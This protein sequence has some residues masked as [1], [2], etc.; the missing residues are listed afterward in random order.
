VVDAIRCGELSNSDADVF[1]NYDKFMI[2]GIGLGVFPVQTFIKVMEKIENIV[3]YHYTHGWVKRLDKYDSHNMAFCI[4]RLSSFFL[5]NEL[6]ELGIDYKKV[7]GFTAVVS[8]DG[9]YKP[10]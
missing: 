4:E 3:N 2:G 9:T 8:A 1:L 6:F 10:K 7:S 5:L